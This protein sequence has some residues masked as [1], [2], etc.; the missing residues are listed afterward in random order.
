[1][2]L[3]INNGQLKKDILTFSL[4]NTQSKPGLDIIFIIIPTTG[5][6]ILS[7]CGKGKQS[8]HSAQKQ[9]GREKAKHYLEVSSGPELRV[10]DRHGLS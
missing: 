3:L 10:V 9:G 5:L 2:I 1:M 7:W 8:N 6:L 4:G